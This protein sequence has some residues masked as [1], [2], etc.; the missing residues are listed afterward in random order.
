[1]EPDLTAASSAVGRHGCSF[2]SGS[3]FST[4]QELAAGLGDFSR[5]WFDLPVDPYIDDRAPYRF[6]RHARILFDP[7]GDRLHIQPPG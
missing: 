1:M 4:E 2:V 6:R 5:A 3:A 7:L